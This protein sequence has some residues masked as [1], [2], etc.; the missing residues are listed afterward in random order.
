MSRDEVAQKVLQQQL[1]KT[2]FNAGR[3]LRACHEEPERMAQ[4]G[5]TQLAGLKLSQGRSKFKWRMSK[6]GLF[7][8]E[9]PRSAALQ[10]F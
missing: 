1:S 2:I 4:P 3:L 6:D 9:R 5:R 7:F 10:P 8:A